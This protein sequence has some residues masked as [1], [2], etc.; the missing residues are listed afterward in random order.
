MGREGL[1]FIRAGAWRSGSGARTPRVRFRNPTPGLLR[2][3]GRT[4]GS[5]DG[6]PGRGG[7]NP[8]V[9]RRTRGSTAGTPGR[10]GVTRVPSRQTGGL[11]VGTA[12]RVDL[13]ATI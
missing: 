7:V 9:C 6:T 8:A 11:P 10:G 5:S 1:E 2:G 13:T 4:R 12:A 3:G